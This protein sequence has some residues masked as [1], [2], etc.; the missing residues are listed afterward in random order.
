MKAQE[1][2]I[3]RKLIYHLYYIDDIYAED[4][5]SSDFEEYFQARNTGQEIAKYLRT[6]EWAAE[7]PNFDFH[8]LLPNLGFSSEEIYY[9]LNRFLNQFRTYFREADI[10]HLKAP[11]D[12]RPLKILIIEDNQIQNGFLSFH[13]SSTSYQIAVAE[14]VQDIEAL[15]K[16]ESF[17]ATIISLHDD[18]ND[19]TNIVKNFP[20]IEKA[21]GR[22]PTPLVICT[23]DWTTQSLHSLI[24]RS[25][26]VITVKLPIVT[27]ELLR[28][29]FKVTQEK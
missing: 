28:A 6:L 23:N 4:L 25:R 27:S 24:E 10:D 8:N 2:G 13:L 16:D 22:Q 5:F 7:N 20:R 29:I 26:N 19:L 1:L 12:E 3:L 18:P 17:D 14:G 15:F 9:F 11:E 21:Q